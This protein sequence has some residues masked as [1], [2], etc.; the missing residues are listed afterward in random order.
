MKKYEQIEHTADIGLRVYGRDLKELFTNAAEGMLELAFERE[1]IS[2]RRQLDVTVSGA[3]TEELLV[4]WLQE[5]LYL[6]EV[7]HL[8]VKDTAVTDIADGTLTAKVTG[9]KFDPVRHV[10]KREIKA[11]AYHD[12]KIER[13][14]NRY[15]VQII[16]DI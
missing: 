5:L 13:K 1:R 12:L 3:D 15:T 11:V 14:R 4:S 2:Q 16:F 7:N 6:F 9:E 10:A 8:I